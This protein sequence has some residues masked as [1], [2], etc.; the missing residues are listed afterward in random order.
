MYYT[1]FNYSFRTTTQLTTSLSSGIANGL[2]I[3]AHEKIVEVIV[4]AVSPFGHQESSNQRINRTLTNTINYHRLD[5]L[6]S[7][8]RLQWHCKFKSLPCLSHLICK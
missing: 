6:H 8:P 2:G 4:R 7:Q 1:D 3:A 5:L